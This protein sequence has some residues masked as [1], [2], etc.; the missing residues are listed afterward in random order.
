M[1]FTTL[2]LSQWFRKVESVGSPFCNTCKK[3]FKVLHSVTA[4]CSLRTVT[5]QCAH[6]FQHFKESSLKRIVLYN[7]AF[8]NG[9][10]G[11]EQSMLVLSQLSYVCQTGRVFFLNQL[12]AG[13]NTTRLVTKAMGDSH[14]PV[15]FRNLC[16]P[17]STAR[18]SVAKVFYHLLGEYLN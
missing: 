4:L 18:K 8:R 11:K 13:F 15:V 16:P 9:K 5:K 2:T 6:R 1:C 12:C 17:R 7:C 14:E 3:F 10:P